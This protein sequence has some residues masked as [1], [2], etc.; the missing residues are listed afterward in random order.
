[1]IAEGYKKKADSA[2]GCFDY[3]IR[4]YSEDWSRA[5]RVADM[6]VHNLPVSD[7]P[8]QIC[9]CWNTGVTG[10]STV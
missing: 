7:L 6:A 9:P 2:G 1:M 5:S 3:L 8:P 10:G 4:D